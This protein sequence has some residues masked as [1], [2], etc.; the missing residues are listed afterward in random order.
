LNPCSGNTPV[1][2]SNCWFR[3]EQWRRPQFKQV[4]QDLE[5]VGGKEM[6]NRVSREIRE[7]LAENPFGVN[8]DEVMA[9]LFSRMRTP[10]T[11]YKRMLWLVGRFDQCHWNKTEFE[12]AA[13]LKVAN[14]FRARNPGAIIRVAVFDLPMTHYGHV[15]RPKQLAG[16]MLM[17]LQWL[18]E[19]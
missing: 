7:T 5:H 19:P 13:D 17:A 2:V 14:E 6:L 8:P 10:E 16:G 15:E 18:V 3:Q 11:G 9:D 1:E 4:L 12:K